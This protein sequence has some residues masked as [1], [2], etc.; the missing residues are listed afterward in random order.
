MPG[1]TVTAAFGI[2]DR[3]QLVG[4]FYDSTG[5]VRGFVTD[6]AAF[7]V[8]DVP[9]AKGTEARGINAEGQIVGDWGDGRI[10]H[11]FIATP[12]P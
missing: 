9:G 5:M 10:I 1:A 11:G 8:V 2:N 6:G 3:G 4:S 7:T 12:S